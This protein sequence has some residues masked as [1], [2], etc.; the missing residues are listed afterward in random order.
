M[1]FINGYCEEMECEIETD[2]ESPDFRLRF[3]GTWDYV[4]EDYWIEPDETLADAAL[5]V[6]RKFGWDKETPIQ[7]GDRYKRENPPK[8]SFPYAN[9]AIDYTHPSNQ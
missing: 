5:R 7:T 4:S 6:C 2:E 8:D 9:S 1:K 3:F